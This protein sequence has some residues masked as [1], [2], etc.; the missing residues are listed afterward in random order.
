MT[1]IATGPSSFDLSNQLGEPLTGRNITRILFPVSV[2]ELYRQ[3]GGMQVLGMLEDLIIF[4]GYPEA[5]FQV[6]SKDN[7]FEFLI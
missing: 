4:G 6:I 2:F 7:F 1:I 5:E 3:F